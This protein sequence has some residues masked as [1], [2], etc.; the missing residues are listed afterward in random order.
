MG[1]FAGHV[2]PGSFFIAFGLWWWVHIL[3]MIA[4]GQARFLKHRNSRKANNFAFELD[5]VST[6]WQKIPLPYFRAVP[7]EPCLKATAATVGIFGELTRTDWRLIDKH[8]NFWRL[9]N[10]A[11]ATMFA[12]FLISASVEILRFYFIVFLPPATEHVLSSLAFFVVG[13]LF[14]FHIDGRPELDQKLHIL[15]YV[16]A[17]SIAIVII[18]EG[19]QRKCF[20]L[21]VTRTILVVLLGTWFF[22]VAHV[23]YGTHPW[24][25]IPSNRAFVAI[26]FSWHILGLLL[27]FLSSLV[28]VSV[29]VTLRRWSCVIS[30]DNGS[31]TRDATELDNL[32]IKVNEDAT[33]V[34]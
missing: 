29:F 24:Q 33:Q 17:F 18:L 22:Q 20:I 34:E 3:A 28:V 27:T 21:F 9:N 12:M 30:F 15:I 2:L 26:A 31:L 4:K 1:S 23:L 7:V 32:I 13:E 11:H 19:W 8:N 25:D 10:F 5:F 6:T 16:V 14:Y